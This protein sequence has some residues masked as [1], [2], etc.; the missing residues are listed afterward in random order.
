VI[1]ISRQCLWYCHHGRAIARVHPVHLIKCITAP[2]GRRPKT[3]PYDLGCE[4]AC[5]GCQSL[6][7]FIF[8]RRF[9]ASAVCAAT[10]ISLSV[11]VYVPWH[12]YILS[13]CRNTGRIS[14]KRAGG[15]HDH[16]A[17]DKMI[18]FW[19]KL[20]Q[21]R[22]WQNILIDASRCVAAMSNR[23]WRLAN[24]FTNF[25]VYDLLAA[26]TP[27]R[28]TFTTDVGQMQQRRHHM[29]VHGL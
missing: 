15:N 12:Q 8:F 2:S 29:T 16:H 28:K 5:T 10:Y 17:T 27:V 3:K 26:G 22:I 6:E 14:M 24:E 4:S 18:T 11:P 21:R 13:L 9:Y 1:T 19:A 25:S 20:E 23:C 7:C